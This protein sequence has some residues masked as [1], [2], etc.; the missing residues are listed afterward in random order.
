[1][2]IQ[3]VNL[4]MSSRLITKIQ[5]SKLIAI[6]STVK[7]KHQAQSEISSIVSMKSLTSH[8]SMENRKKRKEKKRGCGGGGGCR[9]NTKLYPHE[10][11]RSFHLQ[12]RSW[13]FTKKVI[14]QFLNYLGISQKPKPALSNLGGQT[15]TKAQ[16]VLKMQFC[17]RLHHH[18]SHCIGPFVLPGVLPPLFQHSDNHMMRHTRRDQKGLLQINFLS[19]SNRKQPIPQLYQRQLQHKHR[20]TL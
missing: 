1:M 19:E 15:P 2:Q 7:E 6:N 13:D 11:R 9:P 10:K 20:N 4:M 16:G 18:K 8:S 5:K 3:P 12:F 14:F 17:V